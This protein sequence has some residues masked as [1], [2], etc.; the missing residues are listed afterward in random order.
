MPKR[1]PKR[2]LS[3]ERQISSLLKKLRPAW[4]GSVPGWGAT[5]FVDQQGGCGIP[6]HF[7]LHEEVLYGAALGSALAGVP[8]CIAMKAHGLAKSMNAVLA[9][10]STGVS[11]PMVCFVMDD[12]KGKSSDNILPTRKIL[13]STE[14]PV[15]WDHDFAKIL[16]LFKKTKLPVLVYVDCD[17]LTGNYP[18]LHGAP[19]PKKYRPARFLQT[20][21]NPLQSLFLREKLKRS[22]SSNRSKLVELS[23]EEFGPIPTVPDSLPK[24]YQEDWQPMHHLGALLKELS[25]RGIRI[26]GDAGITSLL[27]FPPYHA[28]DTTA[29]LG[30]ST[31]MALGAQLSG[32]ESYFVCGDFSYASA[33]HLGVLEAQRMGLAL[34]GLVFDN[35][36]ARATGGQT[37]HRPVIEKLKEIGNFENLNLDRFYATQ[38]VST[39]MGRLWIQT[40]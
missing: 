35:G 25:N 23:R 40:K 26:H 37:E 2:S 12:R 30:G 21:C 9:S 14:L 27:G 28:I 17:Q 29:Y 10:A 15:V 20:A 11:A 5:E 38:G 13:R 4:I 6:A 19:T 18:K 16:Q 34:S 7:F 31:A 3:I 33:A 8:S 1:M 22:L 24:K 39:R 36:S 32:C